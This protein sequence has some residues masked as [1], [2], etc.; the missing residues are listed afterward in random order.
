MNHLAA[1]TPRLPFHAQASGGQ[2]CRL[3]PVVRIA[4]RG[5]KV[6][7]LSHSGC[8]ASAGPSITTPG[9]IDARPVQTGPARLRH[10]TTRTT[11]E[12]PCR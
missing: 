2:R 6:G 9:G 3:Q 8:A 12:A 1:R 11:E 4:V 7:R 10:H 5:R